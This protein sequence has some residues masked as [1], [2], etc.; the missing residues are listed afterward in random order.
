[1]KLL[2]RSCLA[3]VILLLPLAL[4]AQS[5]NDVAWNK[6][7]SSLQLSYAS[8][9]KRY[10]KHEV[11][12]LNKT[13]AITL[14]AWKGESVYAHVLMWSKVNQGS[15]QVDFGK[16]FNEKRQRLHALAK[17][18]FVS[19]VITDEFGKGCGHRKPN[20]YAASLS[21]D[22]IENSNKKDLTPREVHPLWLT[23]TVPTNAVA[24]TYHTQLQVKQAGKL[25]KSL[26]LNIEVLNHTLP[27]PNQW[28]FHLDLWQHPAA[29]AR[30]QGLKMWS[31]AHFEAMKPLMKR[32]ADAGQ[33]VIT[34]T[35]NKDPWNV[36]TFDP[37][38]DMIV[39]TKKS[40][41]T[42]EY[43]YS[44]FD[45]YV[46]MMLSLGVNKMIN[47]YSIIPWNNR[48]HYKSA[49]EE[50]FI[51]VE[52][53]PGTKT[54]V[55]YWTPF[56]KD[57]VLHLKEKQWLNITNIAMDERSRE[58]MEAAVALLNEVAPELGLSYAD[59]HQTYKRFPNSKDIS[60]AFAH[61]FDKND[62]AERR[63]RGLVSTFYVCCSD[64]FPNTFTFSDPAEACYLGWYT[65]AS[66]FDGLLRWSYNSW[67]EQPLLDSRFRTWPAG[68]TYI[69]YPGNRSSIRF[70]R[71]KEGIQDYE[72]LR[73]IR[74]QLETKGDTKNLNRLNQ[75]INKLA[76][77][78]R[79]ATW[80]DDLNA[81]KTLL[82]SL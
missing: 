24:G 1:M 42:W 81:A 56:L 14:K 5:A 18:N 82:N 52:A 80:N 46:E 20:D 65:M 51:E 57:F 58:Q 30:V 28:Q 69:V 62:I 16:F 76:K 7:D 19:Y 35:L 75:A 68:D 6:L 61:S 13:T 31:K 70:E 37:Y 43:D 3:L 34:T 78:E 2:H 41:G 40:D 73:I 29:I 39:W 23:I 59:N 36:Q 66:G 55:D 15:I 48:I 77:I 11:P 10:A 74:K 4:F 79:T 12:E 72:K 67:V 44:V 22:I 26:D 50:R 63:N 17:A 53:K 25:I 21:E 32:L 71:L 47:C 45:Q 38:A 64:A 27:N 33:K 9:D 8:V 60:I 54:F 49:A